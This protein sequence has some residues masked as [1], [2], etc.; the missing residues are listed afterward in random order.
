M[1][2]PSGNAI[3]Q[4]QKKRFS[5]ATNIPANQT[6]TLVQA[7]IGQSIPDDEDLFSSDSTNDVGLEEDLW[8]HNKPRARKTRA[9]PKARSY[10]KKAPKAR[11][12]PKRVPA[13]VTS[14]NEDDEEEDSPFQFDMSGRK[15]R[16]APRSYKTKGKYPPR[17]FSMSANQTRAAP[18]FSK[19]KGAPRSC[20]TKS[21]ARSTLKM[22]KAAFGGPKKK[23][24]LKKKSA[25]K[26]KADSPTA[27][28]NPGAYKE[29]ADPWELFTPKLLPYL[30]TSAIMGAQSS[31]STTCQSQ[32]CSSSYTQAYEEHQSVQTLK[33]HDGGDWRDDGSGGGTGDYNSYYGYGYGAAGDDGY[34]EGYG[35]AYGYG[36]G[37]R[38]AGGITSE[39]DTSSSS[40]TLAGST[41]K[42]TEKDA[43]KVLQSVRMAALHSLYGPQKMA[44]GDAKDNQLLKEQQAF[45]A[46][47]LNVAKEAF[48][49]AEEAGVE[50]TDA[51]FAKYSQLKREQEAFEAAVEARDGEEEPDVDD[52]EAAPFVEHQKACRDHEEHEHH[53]QSVQQNATKDGACRIGRVLLVDHELGE[54]PSDLLRC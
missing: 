21:K 13:P 3:M 53:D 38:E 8:D 28:N 45:K 33:S 18:S 34:T 37:G 51:L 32:S 14:N 40:G 5:L 30:V 52:D 19:S 23:V 48:F 49:A 26:T 46:A 44:E 35:C 54:G 17:K 1:T 36:A 39:G 11:S 29:T 20:P 27:I 4:E 47:E 24:G 41:H 9:A 31:V 15:S 12:Y 10:P 43:S 42:Q 2:D 6:F 22:K 7:A 25:S 16:A 50:D